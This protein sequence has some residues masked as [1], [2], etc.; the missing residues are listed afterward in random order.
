MT[1][2][3]TID[4]GFLLTESQNSPKHIAGLQILRLP[5]RKR[6]AWLRDLV[7]GMREAKP[8][9]PFN[10]RVDMS[11]PVQPELTTD[12]DL[13]ID[14]HVRHTVLPAPGNDRQLLDLVARLHANLLDRDRPLWEFHLIEGL[15]DRRFAFYTK[16]HHALCDGITFG[17]WFMQ[18][19]TADPAELDSPPIW[20]RDRTPPETEDGPGYTRL[21]REGIKVLGGGVQTAVGLSRLSAR[22]L[23]RRLWEGDTRVALPLSAPRTSLNIVPGAARSVGILEFPLQHIRAIAKAQD[24][25]VND[26]VMTLCDLAV[27][28]YFTEHGDDTR[29]PL[30][31][32]MPVNLRAAGEATDGNLISLLQ[33]RLARDHVNPLD[34]L[35]QISESVHSA[36]EVFGGVS[37]PAIQMYSLLVA[38]IAQIEETFKLDAVLPPVTN[39]VISNVP[40]PKE[41]MYYRGAE[42]L[43]IYPI[44]ALPPLTALNVTACSY[45]GTLFFGLIAARSS[46]PDI[47]TLTRYMS[48]ACD[49]LAELAGVSRD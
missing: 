39:L 24:C 1:R 42:S 34:T 43:A 38:L 15:S 35:H 18:S 44:S 47:S 27:S 41:R 9:Y 32:Y 40:G 29:D 33:V 26:V 2:L 23:A 6:S 8:G 31:A 48:E 25:T 20:Q 12:A 45:A 7:A 3:S 4:A 36:R 5:P 19:G 46:I 37:R 30:V 16:V 13:D 21:V 10:Q 11:N 22:L 14:Y 49:Q 17:R 28:R